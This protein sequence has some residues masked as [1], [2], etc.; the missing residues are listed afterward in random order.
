MLSRQ[1]EMEIIQ[2]ACAALPGEAVGLIGR[3]PAEADGAVLP[4]PNIASDGMFLADPY[5][6]YQA[7]AYLRK[8]GYELQAI[9]HSHPGGGTEPSASD[10]AW[11]SSWSC[12]HVIVALPALCSAAHRSTTR[13]RAWR[14]GP[15]V[16]ECT[17]L[18]LVIKGAIRRS[19]RQLPS[20]NLRSG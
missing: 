15:G 7:F 14:F 18:R 4:L 13:M 10:I 3:G 5:S 19:N 20:G 17:D 9:Y 12:A 2:H 6:Q 11:G 8:Q 1:I 16:G